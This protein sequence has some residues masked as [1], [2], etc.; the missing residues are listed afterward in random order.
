VFELHG[1]SDFV[2]GARVF[3]MKI[4]Q[5]NGAAM[6]PFDFAGPIVQAA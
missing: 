6:H 3:M 4:I 1:S 5:A 2:F